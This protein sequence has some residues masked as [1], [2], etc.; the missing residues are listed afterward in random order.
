MRKY[1]TPVALLGLAGLLATAQSQY[2]AQPSQPA[3]SPAVP[4]RTD[5]L[6]CTG[7]AA[8]RW[9]AHGA[10][11]RPGVSAHAGGGAAD[12]L[13]RDGA[14][15]RLGGTR[16]QFLARRDALAAACDVA[17]RDTHRSRP[18]CRLR[19]PHAERRPST[20]TPAAAPSGRMRRSARSR[21]T[22]RKRHRWKRRHRPCRSRQRKTR[23]P[24]CPTRP[25][26]LASARAA[27][28][29]WLITLRRPRAS[30]PL[31]RPSITC[32]CCSPPTI[33]SSVHGVDV[34]VCPAVQRH[35]PRHRRARRPRLDRQPQL[36]RRL[37]PRRRH[38]A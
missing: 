8:T 18:A 35:Q 21:R 19:Q 10:R 14:D 23:P 13:R 4:G 29:R 5:R 12:G 31:A 37:P 1:V 32:P 34:P 20:G 38:P 25:P 30:R 16:R 22:P 24:C 2:P 27:R 3:G 15:T 33:C 36:P 6:P 11:G 17:A 9:P 7:T 26:A 28:A